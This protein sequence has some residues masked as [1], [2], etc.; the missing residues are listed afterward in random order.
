[1]IIITVNKETYLNH[2]KQQYENVEKELF[3]YERMDEV[4]MGVRSLP[5]HGPSSER[6][7]KELDDIKEKIN[8]VKLSISDTIQVGY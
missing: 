5:Y 7:R 8:F 1:M 4:K 6:F 2:L 3:E